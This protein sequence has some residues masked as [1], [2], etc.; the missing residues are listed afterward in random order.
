MIGLSSIA[1][2][3]PVS[4]STTTLLL[5]WQ[6][7]GTGPRTMLFYVINLDP[8]NQVTVTVDTSELPPYPDDDKAT[9]LVIAPLRQGSAEV[10]P[11]AMRAWFRV[12]AV[13]DG[14]SY[15]TVSVRWGV[16]IWMPRWPEF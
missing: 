7:T 10:G 8:T 2:S 9:P 3:A 4:V 1:L 12:T 15:P 13:T 11:F 5:P 16:N 14:P 6:K